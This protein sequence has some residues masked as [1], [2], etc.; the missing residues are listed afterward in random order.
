MTAPRIWT[1]DPNVLPLNQRI[2]YERKLRI[3][4]RRLDAEIHAAAERHTAILSARR[5]RLAKAD[6][7]ATR[8]FAEE[9]LRGL[10]PERPA[11]I[12]ARQ[13][14]LYEIGHRP[15]TPLADL[16][17]WRS[18]A[19]ADWSGQQLRSARAAMQRTTGP[20]PDSAT[21]AA[22][23]A[24]WRVHKRRRQASDTAASS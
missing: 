5:Q 23:A 2:A 8:W 20:E 15:R 19:E 6:P 7:A 4:R 10:P 11:D 16:D 24:Y 22:A 14:A 18:D 9:I 17:A 1:I 3:L 12:V 13:A 21:R